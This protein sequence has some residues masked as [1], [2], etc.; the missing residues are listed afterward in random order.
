M[1]KKNGRKI[2]QKAW[3]A[4]NKSKNSISEI[5]EFMRAKIEQKHTTVM[6]R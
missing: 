1:G 6:A 2:I 4:E 5:L 3:N